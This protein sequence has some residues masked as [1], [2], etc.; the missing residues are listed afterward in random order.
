MKTDI[1]VEAEARASRGKNEARRTRKAGK[2]PGVVYGAYKD[3]ISIAVNPREI[4]KIV[5][6]ST[7]FNTIFNLQIDG[8]ESTPVMVVDQQ[9]DPLKGTVLHADF[10][11]IDL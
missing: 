3:P 7:G 5:R 8:G 6:S 4:Q 1:T 11:R 2:I 9:L 10:K